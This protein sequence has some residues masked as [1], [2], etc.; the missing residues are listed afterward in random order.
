MLLIKKCFA[1]ALAH[2]LI[3]GAALVMSLLV[4]LPVILFPILA[5]DSYQG[6]NIAHFG[7]DE[8]YYLTRAKEILEGH[9]L[10]Q[11]VLAEG[12]EKQDPT[13]SKA[14]LVLTAPIR[15]FQL[16]DKVSIVTVYNI[17]NF[18]AVFLIV[19]FIYALQ[20]SLS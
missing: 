9:S 8:H 10:G 12:K 6:I 3:V 15:L 11:P 19:I 1:V 18:L 17:Y 14:E 2:R 20:F 5:R 16:Q 7:T 13:F 4:S